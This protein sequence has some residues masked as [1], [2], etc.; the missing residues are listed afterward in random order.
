[1]GQIKKTLIK[2]MNNYLSQKQINKLKEDLMNKKK[3][4]DNYSNNSSSE[5]Y[6][7][8]NKDVGLNFEDNIRNILIFNYGWKKNEINRKLIYCYIKYN[9]VSHI[10]TNIAKKK[11]II[12]KEK[13]I[14][15]IN[16]DKSLDIITGH[17]EKIKSQK[18]TKK[19]IKDQEVII[20]GR[21]DI[22]IDGWF[23]I[24]GFDINILDKNEICVIYKN[25]QEDDIK[26]AKQVVIE[27]KLS[28]NKINELL[29]Q[30]KRDKYVIDKMQKIEKDNIIYLGFINS[31][32]INQKEFYKNIIPKFKDLKFVLFGVKNSIFGKRKVTEFY[33]WEGIIKMD[34]LDKRLK[35]LEEKTEKRFKNCEKKLTN[36]EK[37]LTNFEKKLTNF[38]KKL[39]NLEEKL[40]NKLDIIIQ[41]IFNDDANNDDS[42]NNNDDNDN[43]D[44]DDND[45]NDDDKDNDDGDGD[46]DADNDD[47]DNDN[48]N[49]EDNDADN[50]D[51]DND[52]DDKDNDD[53]N[54]GADNDADNDDNDNDNENNEDNDAD[55]DDKK[56]LLKK[57]RKRSY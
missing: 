35:S 47:N 44:E 28:R 16:K 49:N 9:N 54:N 11:L 10:V 36:F 18:E 51:A 30:L 52:E 24:N 32:S 23:E 8:K 55:N 21:K 20:T 29:I 27:S 37:K 33:D 22:E 41:K 2:K 40:G 31:K 17:L 46:N 14:F 48:E 12:S 38:E 5:Y 26:K 3:K 15:K 56:L 1:M 25:L 34:S 39:T 4:F 43:N 57:K 50:N 6:K 42:E 45:N 19:T 13:V 7:M 53:D